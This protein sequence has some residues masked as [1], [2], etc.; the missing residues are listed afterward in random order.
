MRQHRLQRETAPAR[1]LPEVA[2]RANTYSSS[3]FAITIFL[4]TG[5]KTKRSMLD[6]GSQSAFG[7]SVRGFCSR[8]KCD[9]STM[10]R[11]FAPKHRDQ[12]KIRMLIA[13][14]HGE[15]AIGGCPVGVPTLRAL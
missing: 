4:F 8:G 11:D 13:V 10:R 7:A 9:A 12:L 5:D 6:S 3:Q 2:F 15:D 14:G 1:F